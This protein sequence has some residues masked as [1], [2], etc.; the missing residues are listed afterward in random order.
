MLRPLV[1]I[2]RLFQ[3]VELAVHVS[4]MLEAL[5]KD[6]VLVINWPS[7]DIEDISV[8]QQ[9]LVQEL[10]ALQQAQDLELAI[11]VGEV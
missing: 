4:D 11:Q 1:S 7:S 9:K 3:V 6:S 2:P 5:L 10:L 8:L